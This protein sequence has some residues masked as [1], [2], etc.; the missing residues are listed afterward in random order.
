MTDSPGF[1]ADTFNTVS[2]TKTLEYG[3]FSANGTGI[4]DSQSGLAPKT[5][6][7]LF[8]NTDGT[9]NPVSTALVQDE[10]TS[11]AAGT[12]VPYYA[13]L[14]NT[15]G[16]WS[17]IIPNNLATGVRRIEQRSLADGSLIKYWSDNDGVWA[18][19]STVSQ[20]LG[21]VAINFKTPQI[22]ITSPLGGEQYC[23]KS[24]ATIRWNSRG[25]QT[26]LIEYARGNSVFSTVVTNADGFAQFYNWLMTDITDSSTQLVI[27]LTDAEHTTA[28][29]TSNKTSV[30]TPPIIEVQPFSQNTCTGDTVYLTVKAYGNISKYQWQKEGVDIPGENSRTIAIRNVTVLSSGFYTCNVIGYGPCGINTSDIATV[31]ITPPIQI[32]KQP[33]DRTFALGSTARIS[34]DVIGTNNHKFQWYRGTVPVQNSTR[35]S[36]SQEATLVI[37]NFQ[38]SDAGSNYYCTITGSAICG[39]ATTRTITVRQGLLAANQDTTVACVGTVHQIRSQAV[40]QPTGTPLLYQWMRNGKP[41]T[42]GAKYSGTTTST[43]TINSIEKQ[44]EGYYSINV[45]APSISGDVTV[46]HLVRVLPVLKVVKQLPD[47]EFCNGEDYNVSFVVNDT[48]PILQYA[49]TYLV[50][51][52]IAIT[53]IHTWT[54][55]SHSVDKNTNTISVKFNLKT[56]NDTSDLKIVNIVYL[57]TACGTDTLVFHPRMIP[58]PRI[59]ARPKSIDTIQNGGIIYLGVSATG[60]HPLEYRWKKDG[61]IIDGEF[62]PLYN[63]NNISRSDSGTYECL[64]LNGCDTTVITARIAV[65]SSTDVSENISSSYD[66]EQSIPNPAY[67]IVTVGFTVPEENMTTISLTDLLGRTLWSKTSLLSSGTHRVSIDISEYPAGVYFYSLVTPKAT[68]TKR[69]EVVR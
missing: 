65:K 14:E 21:D 10:G 62:S 15:N 31:F 33:E 25:V 13:N 5:Y 60:L 11:V 9:G 30:F 28:T 54:A 27:R 45:T 20:N 39:S 66:L 49:V 12:T 26:V 52:F 58:K 34:V 41:L 6:I 46:N 47:V 50:D 1:P 61:K 67:S 7:C 19:V 69:L 37:R 29:V 18:G 38:V 63:R 24:P 40:V 48:S 51:G 32:V 16:G 55:K 35:I 22:S 57:K 43:L 23:T 68:I 44:D 64:V 56:T 3:V 42:N 2:S 53:P 17:T 59:L 36:G 8:D 4:Y